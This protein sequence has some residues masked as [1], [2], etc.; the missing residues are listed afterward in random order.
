M[1]RRRRQPVRQSV[2]ESLTKAITAYY[3]DDVLA[4]GVQVSHV[5]KN[6]EFYAAIHRYP[7]SSDWTPGTTPKRVVAFKFTADE[8]GSAIIGLAKVFEAAV[9]RA[10]YTQKALSVSLAGWPDLNDSQLS[11]YD[12][13]DDDWRIDGPEE[14]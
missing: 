10:V 13:D 4:P 9:M 8:F 11:D 12:D 2:L 5:S 14:D 3:A 1:K 7:K 6:N